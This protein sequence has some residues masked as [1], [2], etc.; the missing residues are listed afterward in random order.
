VLIAT[1]ASSYKNA[2]TAGLIARLEG[3]SA[4]IQV[5]DVNGLGAVKPADWNAI[6]LIH[7]WEGGKPPAAVKAFVDRLPSRQKL[8]V[9]TTSGQGDFTMEGVDAVTSASKMVD[10]PA[11]ARDLGNRVDALL[12]R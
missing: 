7:T 5:I 4:S 1:Q 3:R 6:V 10:V 12:A 9:L 11:N 8:V 2:V